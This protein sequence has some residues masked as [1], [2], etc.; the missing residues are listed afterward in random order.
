MARTDNEDLCKGMKEGM[1]LLERV[2][3][4]I[5]WLQGELML[6]RILSSLV[7]CTSTKSTI[8]SAEAICVIPCANCTDVIAMGTEGLVKILV[9]SYMLSISPV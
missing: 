1:I 8:S 6:V 4:K 9:V 7:T 2:H 3:A 5:G